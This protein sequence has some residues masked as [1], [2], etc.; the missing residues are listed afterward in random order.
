IG[1]LDRDRNDAVDVVSD[2]F[3][4]RMRLN[5]HRHVE[6]A[7]RAP[8]LSGNSL[9]GDSDPRA[10]FG[11]LRD[12]DLDRLRFR[13][14]SL[15]AAGRAD[16]LARSSGPPALRARILAAESQ[17]RR[18]AQDRVPKRNLD[19]AGRVFSPARPGARGSTA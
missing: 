15:S 13:D 19:R 9:A 17:R 8:R 6:I 16:D 18:T 3:E 12:T 5:A 7:L 10:V 11:S 14:D 1:L 2:P 4:I